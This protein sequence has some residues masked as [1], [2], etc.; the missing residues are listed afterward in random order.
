MHSF[1]GCARKARS[2]ST[3]NTRVQLLLPSSHKI[4]DI[5]VISL[6][7][8]CYP[9]PREGAEQVRYIGFPSLQRMPMSS[10][11][12]KKKVCFGSWFPVFQSKFHWPR[13]LGIAHYSG[14]CVAEQSCSTDRVVQMLS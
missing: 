1:Q 11:L 13:C 3:H 10:Q 2:R 8:K 14:A 5:S 6:E 7:F 12:I 4:D 9:L